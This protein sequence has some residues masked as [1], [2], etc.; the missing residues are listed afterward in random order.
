VA[1]FAMSVAKKGHFSAI[2]TAGIDYWCPI[3]QGSKL[4]A[5]H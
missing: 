4:K 5:K 3:I 2:I 1:R